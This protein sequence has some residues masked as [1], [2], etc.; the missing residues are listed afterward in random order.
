MPL[1]I[2]KPIEYTCDEFFNGNI[3]V[4]QPS[5]GYRF[6][7]DS[8]ILAGLSQPQKGAT[9]LD[10]GTGCGIIPLLLAHRFPSLR[11]IGVELQPCLAALAKENIQ[12]NGMQDRM[13][14]LC[15]DMRDLPPNSI[16][17]TVDYIISN[18][19]FRP[20]TSGRIN[21]NPQK[22]LAKHELAIDLPQLLTTARN[23]LR[24]GGKFITIY[25]S[26]RLTDVMFQMRQKEIEPKRLHPIFTK[27]K[28]PAE[29]VIIEGVRG[30]RTGIQELSSFVIYC[31]N[32]RYTNKMVQVLSGCSCKK[33]PTS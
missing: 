1:E 15:R 4:L 10:L 33:E 31:S 13:S 32:G 29:L 6:S 25:P 24:F 14:I 5:K 17:T 18:P 26:E 21:P 7:I 9:V 3:K 8:V 2:K 16:G 12:R 19:P 20:V 11:L 30:G 27:K 28:K 23:L 22:A